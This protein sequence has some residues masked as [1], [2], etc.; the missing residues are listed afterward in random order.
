MNFI[1]DKIRHHFCV[2]L[3]QYISKEKAMKQTTLKLTQHKRKNIANKKETN[4]E[5]NPNCL[6]E[7]LD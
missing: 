4:G 2:L 7:E 1:F 5:I 6:K 3:Q